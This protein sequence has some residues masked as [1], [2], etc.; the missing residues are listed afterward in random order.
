MS[1]VEQTRAER[2]AAARRKLAEAYAA[3]PAAVDRYHA[4]QARL[5]AAG[6]RERRRV[7]ELV[8]GRRTP[9]AIPRKPA[10]MSKAEWKVTKARLRAAA[11]AEDAVRGRAATPETLR[12][13][14]AH[15]DGLQQM[16]A[17]GAIDREQHEWAVEIANVYR[18]IE[19]DVALSVASLEARVDNGGG[20]R[21]LVGESVRRIRLHLAYRRWRDRLPQ[22]K[23]LILDMI[24]GDAVGYT[25][26]A[27][28]WGVHHR[29]AR[30]LLIGALDSWPACVGD[31]Y[32]LWS[33]DEIEAA[34]AAE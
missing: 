19:A 28:R 32:R 9:P 3:D 34:R 14:A 10:G 31:A 26:A 6:T 8:L 20:S 23:Q 11:A 5:A 15:G 13:L 1:E 29:K 17:N 2:I 22:P 27:K 24:V 25:V 30:R 16:L 7:D 18:S 21:N 12:K 4:R 33:V